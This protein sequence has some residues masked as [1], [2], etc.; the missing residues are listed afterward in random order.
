MNISPLLCRYSSIVDDFPSFV[1][2]ST[3]PLS[4]CFR[5]NRQRET[6]EANSAWLSPLSSESSNIP[7]LDGAYRL[8]NSDALPFL[9][10][11]LGGL[12]HLQEEVSMLSVHL[13]NPQPGQRVLDLCAAPGNKTAQ[14]SEAVG[15]SGTVV[16]NDINP[17]RLG[18]LRT[19]ADRLGLS[20]VFLMSRDAVH[21]PVEAGLFDCV[22]AD[23]PCSCEGTSRRNPEVL[24]RA[25]DGLRKGLIRK[26]VAILER[27][28]ELCRPGGRVAYSTCTYAPEECESVVSTVLET[29]LVGRQASLVPLSVDGLVTRPGLKRWQG[30]EFHPD[31]ERAL[32][33]W[34]HHNDSGGFF[35][36]VLEKHDIGRDEQISDGANTSA[37]LEPVG[38]NPVSPFQDDISL[39][40]KDDL[41]RFGIEEQQLAPYRTA[42]RS[43]KYGYV[44]PRACLPPPQAL[45]FGAGLRA[46]NLKGDRNRLSTAGVMFFGPK[47]TRNVIDVDASQLKSYLIGRRTDVSGKLNRLP[48]PCLIRSGGL[49]F[50]RGVVSSAHDQIHIESYFPRI[51]A[52]VDVRTRLERLADRT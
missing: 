30:T 31:M 34:P 13:L 45:L 3:E 5:V 4:P 20:N 29:S 9:A 21:F 10:G 38:D 24:Y 39:L 17:A 40:I 8:L 2:V 51:W 44:V 52:G 19:T 48:L 46:I 33:I 22:L 26:Q 15:E 28:L 23:V 41:I 18:V 1:H 7:W 50:G 12:F 11:Y 36:A 43:S 6:S 25:T 42:I 47:A 37:S 32:R 49:L 14:L 16:A 35:V 27:A